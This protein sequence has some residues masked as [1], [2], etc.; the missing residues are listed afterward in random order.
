MTTSYEHLSV[1]HTIAIALKSALARVGGADPL[2]SVRLTDVDAGPEGPY[3][4]VALAA[5]IRVA[6][7]VK[8]QSAEETIA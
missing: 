3:L 4:D 2:V 7:F 6:D 1:T 8:T 5:R